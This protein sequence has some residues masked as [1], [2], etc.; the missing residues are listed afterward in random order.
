LD[1]AH[2]QGTL[3][4]DLQPAAVLIEPQRE[5]PAVIGVARAGNADGPSAT[6]LQYASPERILGRPLSPS[7]DVY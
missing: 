2:A 5:G 7:S 3:H 1:A 4:P 6:G